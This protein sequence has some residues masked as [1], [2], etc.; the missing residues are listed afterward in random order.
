MEKEN[1]INILECINKINAMEEKRMEKQK[2][3]VENELWGAVVNG[4]VEDVKKLIGYIEHIDRLSVF[5]FLVEHAAKH[6]HFE[7]VKYLV[8]HGAPNSVYDVQC[9]SKY[10]HLDIVKYLVEHDAPINKAV[11]W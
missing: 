3:R 2:E 4:R 9:A 1:L 7:I 5:E 10:G 11:L 6:G 8:E